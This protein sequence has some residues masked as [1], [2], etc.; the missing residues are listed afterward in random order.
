MVD[1][2]IEYSHIY[3]NETFSDEHRHSAEI[4]RNL[5]QRLDDEGSSYSLN[6]MVDDYNA[7][8]EILDTVDLIDQLDQLGVPPEFMVF[9]SE[10]ASYQQQLIDSIEVRRLKTEY[11]RYIQRHNKIPCS[12]MIAVWYLLRLGVF[13]TTLLNSVAN[14]DKDR[15]RFV[16]K[17][18]IT[19]LP[20]RFKG[21]ESKARKILAVTPHKD[22]LDRIENI[23]YDANEEVA[24][25][26][27]R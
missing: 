24:Y 15:T 26:S 12:F 21:V 19:V 23:Y 8:D 5:A 3:L 25:G 2:S 22:I 27:L 11:E 4:A 16:G 20:D 14:S 7:S 18:L 1:Y 10:L 6:I 13:E 9:E 17:K